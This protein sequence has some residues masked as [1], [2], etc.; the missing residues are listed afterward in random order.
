MRER[1]I[2]FTIP[3]YG[4]IQ[5]QTALVAAAIARR[6]DV[7]FAPIAGSPIDHVRNSMVKM[8]LGSPDYTHLLMVDSDV[9]PPGNIVD[10]LLECDSPLATGIVPICVQEAIVSNV[11]VGEGD[12][13]HFLTKWDTEG[14]PFEVEGAGTGCVL[15]AREV[16][17]N[18]PWPWFRY[19]EGYAGGKVGEDIFFSRR[20]GEHGYRYVAHPK[21]V[22][23]H[24][25]MFPLLRLVK[26]CQ[27][28]RGNALATEEGH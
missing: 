1:H 19:V 27:A 25:K 26:A 13:S 21:A 3:C 8:L 9:V 18:V 6:S 11:I 5:A 24:Y 28:A 2:L 15:V 16:F 7:T 10:L 23:D 20:A 4:A 22:C 12:Q 14:E 17:E